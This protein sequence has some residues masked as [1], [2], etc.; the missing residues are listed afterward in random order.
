MLHNLMFAVGKINLQF[1][2]KYKYECVG[3]YLKNE[4]Y[5]K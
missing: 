5:V 3:K 1:M 2:N 4:M